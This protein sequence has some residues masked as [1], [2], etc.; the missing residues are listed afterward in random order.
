[1]P[2]DPTSTIHADVLTP[3]GYNLAYYND[4]SGSYCGGAPNQT[5]L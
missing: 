5:Y 2:S 4:V 1:M 3:V